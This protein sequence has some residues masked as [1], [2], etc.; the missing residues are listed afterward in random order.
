MQCGEVWWVNFEWSVG[1][2]IKKQRPAIIVSNNISNKSQSSS[3]RA[4]YQ[5]C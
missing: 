3:G 1:G 4:V 2:E 5:P